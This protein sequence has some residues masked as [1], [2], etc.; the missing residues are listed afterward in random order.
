M[1]QLLAKIG[2]VAML[3]V[4]GVWAFLFFVGPSGLPEILDEHREIQRQELDNQ[5]VREEIQRLEQRNRL[6]REN[7]KVQDREVRKQRNQQREGETTIYTGP[8]KQ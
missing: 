3:G 6:L 7:R 2:Y 4:A 5:R 1:R 8:P